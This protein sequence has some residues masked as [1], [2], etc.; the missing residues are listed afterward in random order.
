MPDGP[1]PPDVQFDDAAAAEAISELNAAR[2]LVGET[3]S[4]RTTAGA[5][6][7][8]DFTGAYAT[9]FTDTSGGLDQEVSALTE[10]IDTL[11]AAIETAVSDAA[12]RRREVT[13]AQATWD[14]EAEQERQLRLLHP[15]VPI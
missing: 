2:R 7:T 6:A 8:A 3:E 5:T 11:R 4:A 14:T 13:A 15:N 9:S 12:Q 1:R 10:G